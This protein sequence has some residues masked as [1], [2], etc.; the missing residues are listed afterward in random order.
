MAASPPTARSAP[1]APFIKVFLPIM[2]ASP[3]ACALRQRNGK[4]RGSVPC[5]TQQKQG[6]GYAALLLQVLSQRDPCAIAP[7]TAA[8]MLAPVEVT[9]QAPTIVVNGDPQAGME[10]AIVRVPTIAAAIA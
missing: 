6:T 5:G 8:F 9:A 7:I 3:F 1:K 4:R 2:L 10:I